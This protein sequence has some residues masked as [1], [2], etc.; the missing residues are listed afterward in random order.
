[1][2]TVATEHPT[3]VAVP[4][5]VRVAVVTVEPQ[6]IVVMFDVEDLGVAIGVSFVKSAVHDHCPSNSTSGLYFIR[7]QNARAPHTKYLHFLGYLF[8]TLGQTVIC[9]TLDGTNPGFGSRQP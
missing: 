2:K 4:G 1:M 5:V 7:H 3:V 6:V 8:I 9:P